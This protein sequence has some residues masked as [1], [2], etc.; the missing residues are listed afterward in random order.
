[1]SVRDA[2]A[3]RASSVCVA[4]RGAPGLARGVTL[5]SVIGL[6]IEPP[7]LGFALACGGRSFGGLLTGDR[8]GITVLAAGQESIAIQC[9]ARDRGPLAEGLVERDANGTPT[10]ARGAASFRVTVLRQVP[11]GDHAFIVARIDAAAHT[12]ADPLLYYDRG[13]RTV[14]VPLLERTA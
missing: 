8:L 6:A 1:M 3:K 9:A 2:L 5:T 4:T 12:P 10:V 14:H 7:L 13:Y 11:A